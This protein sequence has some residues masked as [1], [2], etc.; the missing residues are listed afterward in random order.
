MDIEIQTDEMFYKNKWTQFPVTCR[1]ELRDNRDIT[2]FKVV[3]I[4]RLEFCS[5]IVG[6]VMFEIFI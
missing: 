4:D 2:L 3:G 6:V 5:D 1:N